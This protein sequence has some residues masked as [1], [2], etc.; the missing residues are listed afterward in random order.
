MFE[1]TPSQKKVIENAKPQETLLK[2][3]PVK[4]FRLADY[5]FEDIAVRA[6]ENYIWLN[7][8]RLKSDSTSDLHQKIGEEVCRLLQ[9]SNLRSYTDGIRAKTHRVEFF[10]VF[11]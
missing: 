6:S 11:L 1:L 7:D 3:N 8:P 10:S 4:S 5:N 2:I 9:K